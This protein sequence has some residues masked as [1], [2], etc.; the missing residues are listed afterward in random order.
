MKQVIIG[1]INPNLQVPEIRSAAGMQENSARRRFRG[2]IE[3]CD[4]H[5]Q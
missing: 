4:F 1:P 3:G 2:N 5:R